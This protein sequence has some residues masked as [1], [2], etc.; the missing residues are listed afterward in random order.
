MYHVHANWRRFWGTW[1]E[2]KNLEKNEKNDPLGI[3]FQ[4]DLQLKDAFLKC[5]RGILDNFQQTIPL[6]DFNSFFQQ[7]DLG[8]VSEPSV[9]NA[10]GL[11]Q[12]KKVSR[13]RHHSARIQPPFS[14]DSARIQPAS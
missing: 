9:E 7:H 2:E 1:S 4:I 11:K 6:D 14:Q 3:F 12:K 13:W 10:I 8:W 5:R